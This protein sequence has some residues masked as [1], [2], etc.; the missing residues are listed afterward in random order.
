VGEHGG[1]SGKHGAHSGR[2]TA[3][4]LRH[5][6][7]GL[8]VRGDDVEVRQRR[9]LAEQRRAIVDHVHRPL[10]GLGDRHHQ[11]VVK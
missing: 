8:S 4:E 6:P 1:R 7:A 11:A 10:Y 5:V 3:D 9:E 2:E